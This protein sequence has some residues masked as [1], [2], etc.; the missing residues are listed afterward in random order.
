MLQSK[1]LLFIFERNFT[2]K[3]RLL[4]SVLSLTRSHSRII[5]FTQRRFKSAVTPEKCSTPHSLGLVLGVYSN[6][7]D[8]LDTGQLTPNAAKFNEICNGR[9]YELLRIAGPLPKRGEC[10]LFFNIEQSFSTI[11][12]CGLGDKCLGYNEEEMIDEGKEVGKFFF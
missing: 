1:L 11:A 6:E 10:R 3:M 7:N 2:R 9:L 12:V 4:A 8:M 5:Y